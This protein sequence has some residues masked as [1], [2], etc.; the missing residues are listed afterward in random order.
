MC[1]RTRARAS[2]ETEAA[3]LPRTRGSD[4]SNTGSANTAHPEQRRRCRPA[5]RA[6][7]T[8][9]VEAEGSVTI[10]KSTI[11]GRSRSPLVGGTGSISNGRYC[12]APSAT[13]TSRSV[14]GNTPIGVSTRSVSRRS[15]PGSAASAFAIRRARSCAGSAVGVRARAVTRSVR[16]TRGSV[17]LPRVAPADSFSAPRDRRPKRSWSQGQANTRA[18]WY[19]HPGALAGWSRLRAG[20]AAST[21]HTEDSLRESSI[22]LPRICFERASFARQRLGLGSGP[23]LEGNQAVCF[24]V[25][26]TG[27]LPLA[28]DE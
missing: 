18:G 28:A 27:K 9:K 26:Q 5:V 14:F 25:Q 2:S 10:S 6:R 13:T 24:R 7:C 22:A 1:A 15:A 12:S 4:T 17:R 19:P 20:G 16:F 8:D 11:I 23:A 3:R 21:R